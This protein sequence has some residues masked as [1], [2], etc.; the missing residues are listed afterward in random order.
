MVE[1]YGEKNNKWKTVGECEELK[2]VFA[3]FAYNIRKKNPKQSKCLLFVK[4]TVLF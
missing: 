2:D 3:I 1:V 4:D